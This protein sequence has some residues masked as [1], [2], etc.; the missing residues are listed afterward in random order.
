MMRS[1]EE[2]AKDETEFKDSRE[3]EEWYEKQI[4]KISEK[5]MVLDHEDTCCAICNSG[6]YDES[7][8]IV[9]C[10]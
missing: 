8:E 5:Q 7:N 9:F 2:R 6:D 3:R 1:I 10:G 4:R